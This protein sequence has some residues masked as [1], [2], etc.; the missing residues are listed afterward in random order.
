MI[1]RQI[2]GDITHRLA[3]GWT[4]KVSALRRA[5]DEDDELFY[6]YGNRSACSNGIDTRIRRHQRRHR[7]PAGAFRADAQPDAR[8]LC[9]RQAVAVRARA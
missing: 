8:R 2:F 6:V 7:A 1:E 3:N 9:Q 4:L 5:I